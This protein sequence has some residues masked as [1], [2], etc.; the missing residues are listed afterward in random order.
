[1]DAL[2]H[3]RP[4]VATHNDNKDEAELASKYE[5]YNLLEEDAVELR[6]KIERSL[7]K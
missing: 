3:F 4:I 2:K 5:D 6:E 1:M 7:R